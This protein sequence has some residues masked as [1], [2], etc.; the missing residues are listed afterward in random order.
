MRTPALIALSAL[1]LA[2][3]DGGMASLSDQ[4]LRA[5]FNDCKDL[6][7]SRKIKAMT[8]TEVDKE[9]ERRRQEGRLVCR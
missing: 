4:E 8:C 5:Q 9:C 2:G 1:W 7:G 3:C 6:G